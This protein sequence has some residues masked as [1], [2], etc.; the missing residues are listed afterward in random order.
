MEDLKARIQAEL[1]ENEE[2]DVGVWVLSGPGVENGTDWSAI[3]AFQHFVEPAIEKLVP[4]ATGFQGLFDNVESYL[5][6]ADDGVTVT[7]TKARYTAQQLAE[8]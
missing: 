7:L 1:D 3:V 5:E 8:I 4:L 2:A 6:D